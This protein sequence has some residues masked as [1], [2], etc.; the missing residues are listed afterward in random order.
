M[1]ERSFTVM[2]TLLGLHREKDP[3][4]LLRFLLAQLTPEYGRAVAC[5][6]LLDRASG[7][8]RLETF[9]DASGEAIR[10]LWRA[11][12][13]APM[14]LSTDQMLPPLSAI[15]AGGSPVHVTESMPGLLTHCWG[16]EFARHV[17]GLLDLRFAAI[18]PVMTD[19]GPVGMLALLVVDAWPFDVA[20]E[21]TAHAAA[22]L[23]NICARDTTPLNTDRDIET[24]LFTR[25]YL[26]R[27]GARELKRADRYRRALS[28]VVIEPENPEISEEQMQT[29]A[30]HSMRVMREPDT[31]GRLGRRQIAVILRDPCRW[32]AGLHPPSR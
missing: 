3:Q 29:L 10:R 31:A 14:T 27:A 30:M 1:A 6:Y 18:S 23:A 20:A 22:A 9:N 25:A 24:G 5:C 12:L 26:D 19:D 13:R 28:L 2:N 7:E 15:A 32:G 21:C 4:A 16:E 11:D 8:F 17:Q